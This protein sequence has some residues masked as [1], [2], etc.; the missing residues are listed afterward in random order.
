M[1]VMK[2]QMMMMLLQRENLTKKIH[3]ND[4]NKGEQRRDKMKSK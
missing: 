1:K 3:D 4:E 2:T